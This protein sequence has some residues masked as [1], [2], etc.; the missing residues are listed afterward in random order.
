MLVFVLVAKL[1]PKD[2]QLTEKVF[3][4]AQIVSMHYYD[5]SIITSLGL[6]IE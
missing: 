2:S 6:R 4:G 3:I 5:A 1:R